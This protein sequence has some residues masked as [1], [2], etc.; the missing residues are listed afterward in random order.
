MI[1]DKRN[2]TNRIKD[3]LKLG[4]FF[5]ASV[6]FGA[7]LFG[8]LTSTANIT[9]LDAGKFLLIALFAHACL[10]ALNEYWHIEEDKNNPQF[11]YKPL[12]QGSIKPRN[13]LIFVVICFIMTILL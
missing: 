6:T 11:Q 3:Y 13:A 9:I 7:I 1:S 5:G 8:A 12:V 4:R 10:G 2:I